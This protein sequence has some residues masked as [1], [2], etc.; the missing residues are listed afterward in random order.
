[1]KKRIRKP[2]VIFALPL[3]GA[4]YALVSGVRAT[5]DHI[6]NHAHALD[7]DI[8]EAQADSHASFLHGPEGLKLFRRSFRC[9][10]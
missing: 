1:M 10:W 5:G 8:A 3:A 2:D 6:R 7:R 4:G 9:R